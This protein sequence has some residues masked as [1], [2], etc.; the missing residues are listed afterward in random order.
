MF[1]CLKQKTRCI[2]VRDNGLVVA[3]ETNACTE[4][5]GLTECPRVTACC[6][7]GEGYHL[8][9]SVHAE[10]RAAMSA[11]HSTIPG[12]AYLYGHTWF[13]KDCQ[14]ALVAVNVRTFV[15][16]GESA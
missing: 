6:E 1:P 8:C 10:A 5:G 12:T 7:T 2:I 14:D 15:V 16:T 9:G 4:V 13:C 11:G 3:D